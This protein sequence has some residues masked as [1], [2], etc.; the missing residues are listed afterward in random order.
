MMI[1]VERKGQT[2]ALPTQALL[3]SDDTLIVSTAQAS[4]RITEEPAGVLSVHVSGID[5]LVALPRSPS[6]V[7]FMVARAGTKILYTPTT[8]EQSQVSDQR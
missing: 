2:G 7:R 1:S 6:E 5:T 4:Y 8:H 3:G